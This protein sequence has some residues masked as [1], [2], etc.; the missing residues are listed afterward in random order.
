MNWFSEHMQLFM[1][2]PGSMPS[3]A[4]S[5]FMALTF[6]KVFGLMSGLP[7]ASWKDPFTPARQC[8]HAFFSPASLPLRHWFVL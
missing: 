1:Y 2:Q 3:D 4:P 8:C 6:G 5:S 7:A